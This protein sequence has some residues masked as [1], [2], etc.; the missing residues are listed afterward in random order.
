[1]AEILK[2]TMTEVRVAEAEVSWYQHPSEES[3]AWFENR[4][5]IIM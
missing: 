4:Q 5:S 3:E 2:E 1:M